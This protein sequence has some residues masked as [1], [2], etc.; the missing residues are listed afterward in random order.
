M[1]FIPLN[2]FL[3]LKHVA[4]SGGEAKHFIKE[5]FIKLNGEVETRNKKKLIAGDVIEIDCKKVT[6]LDEDIK[7]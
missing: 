5:G 7:G 2:A 4:S 3:K 1:K 6:V